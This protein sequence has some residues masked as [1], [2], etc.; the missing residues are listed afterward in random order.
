MK[1]WGVTFEGREKL[2]D[3]SVECQGI[4]ASN[5]GREKG[6]IEREGGDSLRK[7]IRMAQFAQSNIVRASTR[8]ESA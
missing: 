4:E 5:Q 3:C 6:K 2:C 8:E 1:V 7:K